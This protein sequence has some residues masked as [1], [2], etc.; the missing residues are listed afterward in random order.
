MYFVC[1]FCDD[2]NV[3]IQ[4]VVLFA[5]C[6]LRVKES[7]FEAKRCGVHM[8]ACVFKSL[9]IWSFCDGKAVNCS[10]EEYLC[11]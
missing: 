3:A 9:L 8:I 1:C 5:F 11:I 6:A 7:S 4:T 2:K 10:G